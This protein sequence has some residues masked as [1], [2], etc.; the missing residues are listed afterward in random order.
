MDKKLNIAQELLKKYNQ[1]H[2]IPFL[3]NGKNVDLIEQVLKIDFEEIKALYNS[4]GK[5]NSAHLNEI[6][7]VDAVNPNKL[8]KASLEE[9][10]SIGEEIIKQNKYA[11]VTMAGRTRNKATVIQVQRGHLSLIC[12]EKISICLN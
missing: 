4:V 1:E 6:S 3:D 11:V 10:E 12:L 5:D 7:P 8:T 2:I 9:I